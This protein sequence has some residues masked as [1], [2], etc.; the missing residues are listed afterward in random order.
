MVVQK[1]ATTPS[2]VDVSPAKFQRNGGSGARKV[3][4]FDDHDVRRTVWELD[5]RVVR[6][7]KIADRLKVGLSPEIFENDRVVAMIEAP[8]PVSRYGRVR[9][10]SDRLLDLYDAADDQACCARARP[11]LQIFR[12]G[13]QHVCRPSCTRV[14]GG[15]TRPGAKTA[16]QT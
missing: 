10:G 4:V 2:R 5:R 12:V 14:E 15:P 6:S 11:N 7:L 13:L 1:E 8:H 3:G 9:V 16:R